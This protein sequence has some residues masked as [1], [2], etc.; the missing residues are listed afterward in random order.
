MQIQ[1]PLYS[2]F[3]VCTT[4]VLAFSRVKLQSLQLISLTY[5]G[6]GFGSGSGSGSGVFSF[7]VVLVNFYS[8]RYC[9]CNR[10]YYY[11][12]L[13]TLRSEPEQ[14][15]MYNTFLILVLLLKVTAS[16]FS[17]AST[18]KFQSW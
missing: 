16:H 17:G 10:R 9:F 1:K 3:F 13:R 8:H 4:D 2:I 5:F 6:C 15:N 14:Y 11:D 12:Y 7:F 18:S